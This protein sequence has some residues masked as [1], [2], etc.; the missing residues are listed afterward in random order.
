M[1]KQIPETKPQAAEIYLWV[2]VKD[3]MHITRMDQPSPEIRNAHNPLCEELHN[4]DADSP[5]L[6]IIVDD[7]TRRC[8]DWLT[9]RGEA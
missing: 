1:G 2:N 4:S 5:R 7:V 8:D 6:D 9:Q 3:T